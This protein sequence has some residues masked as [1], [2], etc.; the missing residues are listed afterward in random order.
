MYKNGAR[1]LN[2]I[3]LCLLASR[4][5]AS[6]LSQAS[7]VALGQIQLSEEEWS[8]IFRCQ[9]MVADILKVGELGE[10]H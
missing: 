1:Q 7:F 8:K 4:S 3:M 6:L 10:K 9:I 2:A 5:P